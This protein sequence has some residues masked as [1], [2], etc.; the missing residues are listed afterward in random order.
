M[1]ETQRRAYFLLKLVI[2]FYPQPDAEERVQLGD[3]AHSWK[4]EQDLAWALQFVEQNTATAFERT[5][6]WL[7]AMFAA[8]E[9]AAREAYFTTIWMGDERQPHVTEMQ[10]LALMRLAGG[11]GILPTLQRLMG[12]P[13]QA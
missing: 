11:W 9:P 13:I 8:L 7:D 10:G 12:R 5:Q 3:K 1:D 4:A 6:V 2:F